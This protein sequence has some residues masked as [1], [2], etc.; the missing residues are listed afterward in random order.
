MS[1]GEI[2]KTAWRITWRYRWLW[3]LG[4]FAGV[5]GGSAGGGSSRSGSFPSGTS[6]SGSS[7][8]P[9]L[10]GLGSLSGSMLT[11]LLIIALAVLA[12]L[13]V[14][15]VV[16]AILGVAARGG[17]V[18]AVNEIEDGRAARLGPAWSFGFSRFWRVFGLGLLLGLPMFVAVL[19]LLAGVILPFLPAIVAGTDPSPA[20]IVPV[21]GVLLIGLPV[22]VIGGIALSIMFEMAL[23]YVVL[24]DAHVVDSAKL[25]WQAL[26]G[27]FKDT[28]LMWLINVGLNV[29]AGL[30]LTIPILIVAMVFIVPAVLAGV[31]GQWATVAG[32][33]GV[34]VLIVV[35]ASMV[36]TAIWGTFTSALWTDYFRRFVGAG[37]SLTAPAVQP[38]VGWSPPAGTLPPPPAP[39][40]APAPAE[41]AP[42]PAEPAP[43]PPMAPPSPPAPP[44]APETPA[45]PPGA[46]A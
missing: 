29:G 9:S 37:P 8:I 2:I 14:L 30:V 38:P 21:C 11:N 28:F 40:P 15:G 3:V 24:Q 32:T 16:W 33:V 31:A 42:A 27:R 43:A 1:Y 41:P 4:L 23:R 39:A 5:T 13:I 19:L 12:V 44:I 35:V 36:Y 25:G 10:G 26:R 20:T 18:W 17:L 34:F 46:G 7:G 6:G 22:L 45:A